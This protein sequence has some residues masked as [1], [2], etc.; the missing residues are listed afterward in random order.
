MPKKNR[1]RFR[2]WCDKK[3]LF[4]IPFRYV[5][6]AHQKE[7]TVEMWSQTLRL[8]FAEGEDDVVTE[9]EVRDYFTTDSY[10]PSAV[11]VGHKFSHDNRTNSYV[12]FDTNEET[13]LARKEKQGGPIGKASE[14]SVRFTDEKTWIRVRDGVELPDGRK[15]ARWM[16]AYGDEK[17][18][19]FRTEGFMGEAASRNHPVYDA[20]N[21]MYPE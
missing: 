17:I 8:H 1:L 10:K 12:H 4:H 6:M 14:V 21:P 16:R 3:A 7:P 19:E 11:I 13:I 2:E 15:R 18:P 9:E 20:E 5:H